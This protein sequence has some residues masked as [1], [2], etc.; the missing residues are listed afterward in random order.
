MIVVTDAFKQRTLIA[1]YRIA[2]KKR[3]K[4]MPDMSAFRSIP[5]SVARWAT[6]NS[7]R[8]QGCTI[9]PCT[10]VANV[11]SAHRINDAVDVQQVSRG[12]ANLPGEAKDIQRSLRLLSVD[13]ANYRR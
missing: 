13:C 2:P 10:G 9:D 5:I 4:V 1:L 12:A 8:K 3:R 11:A 6:Q 7:H